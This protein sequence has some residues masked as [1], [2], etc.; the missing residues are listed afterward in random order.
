MYRLLHISLQSVIHN[1]TYFYLKNVKRSQVLGG[2]GINGRITLKW[3][4]ETEREGVDRNQLNRNG[5][6][7]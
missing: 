2:P 6:E 5:V 7:G 3:I 4:F 1:A